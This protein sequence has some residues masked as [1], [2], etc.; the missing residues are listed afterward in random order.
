MQTGIQKYE[1]KLRLHAQYSE[2][3]LPKKYY[4]IMIHKEVSKKVRCVEAAFKKKK[5]VVCGGHHYFV[6]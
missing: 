3:V 1:E 4:S 6:L 2:S 5:I